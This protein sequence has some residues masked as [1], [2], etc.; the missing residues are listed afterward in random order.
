MSTYVDLF[1]VYRQIA[2]EYV[3]FN[4]ICESMYISALISSKTMTNNIRQTYSQ[5]I[6]IVMVI[7]RTPS[8]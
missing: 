1:S 7:A 8:G 6:G 4:S 5:Q 2:A 3:F